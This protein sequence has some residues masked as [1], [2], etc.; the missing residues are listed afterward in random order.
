HLFFSTRQPP[1]TSPLF[2][3]TTL[4]RSSSGNRLRSTRTRTTPLGTET[5]VT[6]YQYDHEIRLIKTTYPDGSFV[7]DTYDG[8]GQRIQHTDRS[9]E[10]RVGKESRARVATASSRQTK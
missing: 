7:Q 6:S 4:F 1:P 8:A 9:E 3:Y 10:R 5:L 2:P